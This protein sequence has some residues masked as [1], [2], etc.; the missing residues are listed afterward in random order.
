[1]IKKDYT[2]KSID[3]LCDECGAIIAHYR[4]DGTDRRMC[5][6]VYY[7]I[8]TGNNSPESV[9]ELCVCPKCVDTIIDRYKMRSLRRYN[10]E[11]IEI[12]H[13]NTCDLIEEENN[14]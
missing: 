11:Y 9:K 4:E 10:T 2:T 13:M 5:F 7:H 6:D 1:M 8:I 14:D 3:V 12:N